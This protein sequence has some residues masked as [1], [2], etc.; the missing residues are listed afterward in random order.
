MGAL[1]SPSPPSRPSP[2]SGGRGKAGAR[3][4]LSSASGRR[5][6]AV[7]RLS[8]SPSCGGRLRWGRF[9]RRRP[10]PDLLPRAGEGEMLALAGLPPPQAE[11]GKG[12]R[13]FVF[14]PRMRGRI[15]VG[16]LSS[17]SPPSRPSPANGGRG[18]AGAR[19]SLSSASG[20][21]EKAVARLSSSPACGGGSRWGLGA[22]VIRTAC[23][24][25]CGLRPDPGYN[26]RPPC[27]LVRARPHVPFRRRSARA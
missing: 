16:A 14:L 13:P 6:K 15:E 5:G 3:W 25:G 27:P 23:S 20:R 26:S 21:R 18:K 4:S 8:S 19:W 17:P 24:P 9:P 10:H 7:A 2:A 11:K 22:R 1:S 12:R